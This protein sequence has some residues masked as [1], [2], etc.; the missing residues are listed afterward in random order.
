[1]DMSEEEVWQHG[2]YNNLVKARSILCYWA[3]RELGESMSSMAR[4]F[5]ISTVAVSKSV[6]R[7]ALIIKEESLKLI[8]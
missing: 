7:G 1:M 4:K 2:K 8:S 5:K 3:V 6:K